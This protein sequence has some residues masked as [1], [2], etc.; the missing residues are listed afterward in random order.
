MF[1][2]YS[3]FR[4]LISALDQGRID[5]ALCGGIALA[6]YDHPRTTVDID[7][8]ILPE[9]LDSVI[10]IA[11]E[12]GYTIRGLEMT[13]SNGAI[14]IRRVSKIDTN[15]G[16]VLSL[17]LLLVTPEIQA[18]WDSRV[19]ADWEGGTLSVVSREGLIELKKMRGSP[20]D[21]ADIS[22]LLEDVD[23]ATN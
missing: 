2:L 13:F 23:D 8:L 14:E 12:L 16:N 7:L 19:E 4:R 9:S 15:T 18:A 21:H 3:E 20:Q 1:D 17:D 10:G 11:T 6:I 22:A 5:Y